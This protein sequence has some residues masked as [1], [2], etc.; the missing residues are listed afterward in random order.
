MINSIVRMAGMTHDITQSMCKQKAKYIAKL[1]P[2]PESML[3][4]C[5]QNV[6]EIS[7]SKHIFFRF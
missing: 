3:A 2:V 1:S 5:T 6:R 4:N 7:L